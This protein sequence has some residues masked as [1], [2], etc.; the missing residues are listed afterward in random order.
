DR[1]LNVL[2]QVSLEP[3]AELTDLGVPP[4]WQF[5][6]YESD[7]KVAELVVSQQVFQRSYVLP[8]GT[9]AQEIEILR[10]AFDETMRDPQ[11]LADAEKMRISISPL[12]G[13]E[14]QD[15]INKLY[16]APKTSVERAKAAIK[17]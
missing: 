4:I 14:V 1:K 7:C 9:P 8:P 11:F 12:G 6:P 5:I 3:L 2:V 13:S 15:V 10:K 16:A 17:P